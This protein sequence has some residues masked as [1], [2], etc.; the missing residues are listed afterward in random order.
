[1]KFQVLHTKPTPF[2]LARA[3]ILE[4]PHGTIETPVFMPVGTLAS[5][6]AMLPHELE[7]LGAQIILNNAFHLHLRPGAEVVKQAGGLHQFQVGTN[8]F[9][10]I[11][12]DFRFFRS[13]KFARSPTK[14]FIFK[15]PSTAPNI[16]SRP[17]R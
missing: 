6:K 3:G 5:V 16:F 11:P 7:Q 2:G 1:V 14:A 9:S 8:R 4:L 15:V 10:P 13:P 12:A 17:N